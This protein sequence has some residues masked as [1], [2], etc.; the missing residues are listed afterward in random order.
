MLNQ[1]EK[2]LLDKL[3]VYES[4]VGDSNTKTAPK[5]ERFPP[6]FESIPRNPIVIDLA[7]TNIEFPEIENRM[8][9]SRTGLLGRFFRWNFNLFI[10]LVKRI[11]DSLSLLFKTPFGTKCMG[12]FKNFNLSSFER[13]TI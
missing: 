13:I 2:Y 6:A 5:I 10:S 1:V 12:F 7:H 3:D 4:A 8:K 9:K 11:S